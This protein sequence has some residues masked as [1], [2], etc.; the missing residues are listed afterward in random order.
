MNTRIKVS[1]VPRAVAALIAAAVL[2]LAAPA[3]TA[4][5]DWSVTGALDS[6]L[7]GSLTADYPGV[8]AAGTFGFEQ[9]ANLRL[10]ARAGDY[11]TVYAAANLIAA[12]GRS[13]LPVAP[14]VAG[15]YYA[16]ALELERLYFRIQGE[17]LD[18]SIG[19]QRL[20]FGYGQAW[21]PTDFLSPR[22]PLVP[23]A[24]PRGVLAAAL[25]WYPA[26]GLKLLA[27]VAAGRD[28]AQD[29]GDGALAGGSGEYH[30]ER[31]SVQ[32]L[33]AY[34]APNAAYGE[35]VHRAG[36]SVKA[37][38]V[39]GFAIDALYTYDY[40]RRTGLRGLQAS[41]GLDYSFLDGDLYALCQYL[42]HGAAALDPDDDLGDLYA[43]D[44]W[45]RL[46]PEARTPASGVVFGDGGLNRR[47]YL[48]AALTY[49]LDD[50]TAL[51]GSAV[52]SLDDLSFSPSLAFE[53]EPF[54]GASLGVSVRLPVDGPDRG[55][56][57]PTNTGE[58]V[59]VTVKAKL[60]F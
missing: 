32:T 21:S 48:Y 34:Q 60:R 56:L 47:D 54:Q 19:L 20:A 37:D 12:T 43:E 52:V 59:A 27:F 29:D 53:H 30:G 25:A 35:G 51:T 17:T 45:N 38:A 1:S 46:P 49:R 11:G 39:V 5:D 42:Y 31:V 6:A 55:E 18:A 14:F 28:P 40:D 16:A 3:F 15:D 24:R 9:Y 7:S 26:D 50:Y 33:Y 58:R 57:G 2:L 4:A 23:D 8:D 41:A 44:D 13:A 22:N 36:L 10:K